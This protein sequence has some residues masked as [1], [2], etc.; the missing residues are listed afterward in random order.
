MRRTPFGVLP[1]GTPVQ[2]FTWTNGNGVEVA[3]TDYGAAIVS[4]RAPDRDGRAADIVLG[5]DTLAEYRTHRAYFGAIVG[6]CANRI[7]DARFTLAGREWRLTPNAPP[8]HLHGGARGFDK[9]VWHAEP[10]PR[11][12]RL[13]YRSLAGEEGYP[14]ALSVEVR[15]TLTESNRLEVGY[16]ATTDAAT[17]VNLTQHSY[18]NLAGAGNVLRH[19]LQIQA[20]GYTPVDASLIPTGAIAPVEGTPLDFRLPREIGARIDADHP[21]LRLAGGYDH[22]F[23]IRREGSGLV[24]AARVRDPSTGRTLEVLTTEPGMQLYTANF[25]EPIRGKGGRLYGPRA[26]FCLETQQFPDA[27]NVRAFPTAILSPG[28]RYSSMTVFAFGREP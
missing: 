5:F 7:R 20:D 2:L 11:E 25:Q 3:V 22:N 1:D 8:H 28:T 23:V 13:R 16:S 12:L 14:G 17:P 26:G 18:F 19:Q 24:P 6:R 21:Q 4:L 10:R 15:Y 27:P 9:V